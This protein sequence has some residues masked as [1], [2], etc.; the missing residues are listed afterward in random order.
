MLCAE[1]V[2]PKGPA[3]EKLEEGDVLVQVGDEL[4]TQFARLDAILDSSVGS[5]VKILVQR[6]GKDVEVELDVEDL[7]AITPVSQAHP[8]WPPKAE[9]RES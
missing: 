7:H 6:G 3:H 1:V 2:L 9:S 4:L 8:G 5:K